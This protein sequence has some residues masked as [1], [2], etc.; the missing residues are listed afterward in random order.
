MPRKLRLEYPGAMYRV[1]S[2]GDQRD[3]I[4]PDDVDRH[5][6]VRTLAEARQ[7][8]GWQ[9]HAFCLMRNHYHL[10]LETPDANLVWGMAWS[11]G[12]EAFPQ[13][14]LKKMEG[15]AGEN[16]PGE[17]RLETAEAKADRIVAEELARLRWTRKNLM[18]RRRSKLKKLALAA[19]LRQET[20]LSVKQIAERVGLG[21]PGGAR[22]N[23]HKFMKGSETVNPQAQL[24]L[25]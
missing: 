23:L 3:N 5:D 8:A 1:M 6:F 20:R 10:V 16:H 15:M 12:G 2:R 11:I 25:Q 18:A 14:W 13:Q 4:F 21:K 7:K 24:D 22:A 19:R 9:A 17:T